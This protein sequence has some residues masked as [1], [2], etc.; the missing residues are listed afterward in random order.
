MTGPQ[1]LEAA[2]SE[3]LRRSGK[4][5]DSVRRLYRGMGFPPAMPQTESFEILACLRHREEAAFIP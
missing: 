5:R 2:A 1:N 4:E 3:R